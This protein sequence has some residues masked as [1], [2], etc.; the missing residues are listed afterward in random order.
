M[1]NKQLGSPSSE[2]CAQVVAPIASFGPQNPAKPAFK[3]TLFPY[4]LNSHFP[5]LCLIAMEYVLGTLA[6]IKNDERDHLKRNSMRQTTL[7]KI[8]FDRFWTHG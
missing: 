2:F 8:V 5:V 3:T 6:V 7:E 4:F 1:M